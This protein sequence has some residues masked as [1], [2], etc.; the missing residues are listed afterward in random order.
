[1]IDA[2]GIILSGDE[3]ITPVTDIRSISALP[4]AGSYRLID[5][6]LS[7]MTNSGIRNVGVVTTSNYK[8][9]MDHVKSGKPWDLDRKS[10]GLAILPPNMQ[11]AKYGMLRGD[12]DMLEGVYEYIAQAK[13]TYVILSLGTSIYNIN[14]EE[15]L[16]THI[17]NQADITVIYKKMPELSDKELSRFTLVEVAEDER[18]TDIEIMPYYPK[19][20]NT[21]LDVYVMERALL[22]SILDECIARGDHDLMK[23]AVIKKLSALR[24]FG[25]EYKGYADKIDSLKSYFKNNM[26]FLD[27]ELKKEMLNPENPIYTKSKDR[28]PTKYGEN[29]VVENSL[30]ADG[31]IIEGAVINSVLSRGVKVAKGAI[32]KNSILM[33][34]SVIDE[35]VSLDYVIFDKHVHVTEGRRLL[36][37][38]S[39]P[40]AIGKGG[41]I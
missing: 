5:F 9:L 23:D 37:Q 33:Q 31:C 14:F 19:T 12:I 20:S 2:R 25:Y 1:M 3:K 10:G 22:C 7:N 18:V 30:I 11:K 6:V 13:E 17:E 26:I 40:L 21:G 34:D 39:Y 15:V 16:D 8:S 41:V 38:D 32:V 24:V 36:G 35:S 29:A 4:I 28:A 27:N